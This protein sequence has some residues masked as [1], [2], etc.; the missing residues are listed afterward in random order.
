MMNG[1]ESHHKRGL[2]P[3]MQILKSFPTLV[4]NLP[5]TNPDPKLSLMLWQQMYGEGGG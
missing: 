5:D 3:K 2:L 1:L 4:S